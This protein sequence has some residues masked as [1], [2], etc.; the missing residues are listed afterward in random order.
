[1]IAS[2]TNAITA[3]EINPAIPKAPIPSVPGPSEVSGSLDGDASLTLAGIMESE[4]EL[5]EEL[6][7]LLRVESGIVPSAT[8]MRIA[9]AAKRQARPGISRRLRSVMGSLGLTKS[10]LRLQ[11]MKRRKSP[12][13]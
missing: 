12:E 3:S 5:E 7:E 8:L 6:E 2:I 9:M 11:E 4:E 1:M 13:T 10:L